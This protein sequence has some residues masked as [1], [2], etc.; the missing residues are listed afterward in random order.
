MAK[1]IS[2]L[3]SSRVPTV[4]SGSEASSTV[5]VLGPTV[6][7]RPTSPCPLITVSS[8]WMPSS[9][10]TSRVTVQ[11]K[12]WAAPIATTCAALI[13][14][15]PAPATPRSCCTSEFLV[16]AR[17]EEASRCLRSAFCRSRACSRALWSPESR[18]ARIVLPT[19]STAPATALSAGPRTP[20]AA[21]RA[22]LSGD[23]SPPL[24]ST[25]INAKAM[26][27]SRTSRSLLSRV[28]LT[29]LGWALLVVRKCCGSLLPP[30]F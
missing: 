4:N 20:A 14:Y 27:T 28:S 19:G 6:V 18:I 26:A 16:R 5:E 29:A 15:W 8:R 22:P 11:E 13:V 25:V 17:S 2:L 21:S 7:T 9:L 1:P 30:V 12:P 24:M 23:V 3:P 10:P